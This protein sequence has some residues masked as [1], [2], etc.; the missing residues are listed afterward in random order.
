VLGA[1]RPGLPD[2]VRVTRIAAARTD[3]RPHIPNPAEEAPWIDQMGALNELLQDVP[4][5]LPPKRD[6]DNE[7]MRVK[8]V[9]IP[10]TH[11]FTQDSANND[12]PEE[13]QSDD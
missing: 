9:P 2:E 7:M 6:I 12:Q 1:L 10:N 3:P 13:D 8:E 4:E 5:L 11:A